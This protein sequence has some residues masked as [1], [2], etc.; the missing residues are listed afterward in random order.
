MTSHRPRL[1]KARF[2]RAAMAGSRVRFRLQISSAKKISGGM[3]LGRTY[4]MELEGSD[5]PALM[6]EMLTLVA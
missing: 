2:P 5:K 3:L 4:T 6:A 1:N